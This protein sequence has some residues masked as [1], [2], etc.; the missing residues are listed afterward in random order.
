[1]FGTAG[2]GY[3][4]KN[5]TNAQSSVGNY[6]TTELNTFTVAAG[7]FNSLYPLSDTGTAI[8]SYSNGVHY[9]GSMTGVIGTDPT[10]LEIG[11]RGGGANIFTGDMA[12]IVVYPTALSDANVT[13]VQ[14][15]LGHKYGFSVTGC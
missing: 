15:Y 7:R 13:A 12:E 14:C 4:V 9:V 5:A 8:D 1:M 6:S 2:T 10:Y 3:T 11:A